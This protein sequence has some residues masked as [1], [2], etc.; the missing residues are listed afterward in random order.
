MWVFVF[1]MCS[2][3]GFSVLLA[4]GISAAR[5]DGTCVQ[6]FRPSGSAICGKPKDNVKR[7]QTCCIVCYNFEVGGARVRD[8]DG[9]IP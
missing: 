4:T 1:V 5:T 2:P 6:L 3:L 7:S 9:V 8:L